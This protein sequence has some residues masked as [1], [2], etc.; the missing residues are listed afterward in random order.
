MAHQLD[1]D[2]GQTL[3]RRFLCTDCINRDIVMGSKGRVQQIET[4]HDLGEAFQNASRVLGPLHDILDQAQRPT[5]LK[6]KD[7]VTRRTRLHC[8]RL[9]K[10]A[11]GRV[12][13]SL[14]LSDHLDVTCIRS[15]QSLHL[16]EMIA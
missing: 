9:D 14:L 1:L 7:I 8:D 10:E 16:F 5:L 3:I 4:A 2:I 6:D 12:Q 13:Q 11:L 15:Q